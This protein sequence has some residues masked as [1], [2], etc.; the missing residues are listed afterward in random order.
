MGAS[1]Y[2][3]GHVKSN[4]KTVQKK[5]ALLNFNPYFL[6]EEMIQLKCKKCGSNYEKPATFKKWGEENANVFFKWSLTFCDPCRKE[7]EVEALTNLPR[8][9][10]SLL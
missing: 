3:I 5:C 9:L 2:L 1:C 6:M 4:N 7:K 8:V 10:K